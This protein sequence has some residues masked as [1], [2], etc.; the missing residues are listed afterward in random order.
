MLLRVIRVSIEDPEESLKQVVP[1]ADYRS[2]FLKLTRNLAP[3]GE[4][5]KQLELRKVSAPESRPIVLMPSTRGEITSVLKKGST[6]LGE[7][8]GETELRGILR[9]LHLDDDWLQIDVDSEH[10]IRVDGAKEM[11]DDVIG[12]MV[13]RQ[14]LVEVSRTRS[15]KYRFRDIQLAE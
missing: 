15:G 10:R 7:D 9:A 1:S 5:F 14:V 8:A 11:V 13:N 12:P 4:T 2:T 6:S 3:T